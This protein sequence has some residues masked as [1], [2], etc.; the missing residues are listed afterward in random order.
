[1]EGRQE[2]SWAH[3]PLFE[4]F[5]VSQAQFDQEVTRELWEAEQE[6]LEFLSDPVARLEYEMFLDS[7]ETK[8][9]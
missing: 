5:T 1:M 8:D 9:E 3:D 2:P 4:V 6:A 7:L